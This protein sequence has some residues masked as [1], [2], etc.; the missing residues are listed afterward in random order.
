MGGRSYSLKKKKKRERE[1]RINRRPMGTT[2]RIPAQLSDGIKYWRAGL[3][4]NTYDV[5]PG[6][7]LIGCAWMQ[8]GTSTNR[9]AV[10]AL[11]KKSCPKHIVQ[12]LSAPRRLSP[13]LRRERER[14]RDLKSL[15]RIADRQPES[16]LV[17]H[18]MRIM[19]DF[20]P[21]NQR[22]AGQDLRHQGTP[23][24]PSLYLKT[25]Q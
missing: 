8:T 17:L 22:R 18:P 23:A 15:N 24:K 9:A 21:H 1:K 13:I 19:L 11:G 5:W 12:G 7:Q 6:E 3:F 14:E 16:S 10:R 25:K 4:T 20:N 2:T